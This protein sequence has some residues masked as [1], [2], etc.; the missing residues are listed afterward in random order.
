M[1]PIFPPNK[2]ATA[3][4]VRKLKVSD[5]RNS[6]K[7]SEIVSFVENKSVNSFQIVQTESETFHIVITIIEKSGEF[8]LITTRGRKREWV[9]LDRLS[10]HIRE[11]Y[12]WGSNP[13]GLLLLSNKQ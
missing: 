1:S 8:N 4:L 11:V 2:Q 13:I 3:L 5:L 12:R 9:S 6:V 7:E 10:R